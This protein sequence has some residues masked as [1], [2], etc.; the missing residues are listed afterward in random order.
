MRQ[1]KFI[2]KTF[3]LTLL[4]YANS[5]IGSGQELKLQIAGNKETGYSVDIYDGDQLLMNND[6]EFSLL[7]SNLDLSVNT[8]IDSWKADNYQ[9]SENSITLKKS[10]YLSKFDANLSVRVN[11]ELINKNVI[12]KT[13]RLYQPSIP[14]FYYTL[15]ETNVPAREPKSY[16]TFEHEKFPGGFVHELYPSA[17]FITDDNNVVGFLTDAGFKNHFTRTTR[18]RFSENGGGM[19]GM[20]ILPDIELFTVATQQEQVQ[21]KHYVRQTFGRMYDLDGG[22]VVDLELSEEFEKVGNV[23]IQQ[24][25]EG[26]NLAIGSGSKSGINMIT[27]MSGQKI[28]S[29]SFKVKGDAPVAFKL[30]QVSNGQQSDELEHGIKYIDNFTTTSEEWSEFKGSVMVPYIGNDSVMMFLGTTS[31][32]K[33]TIIYVKDLKISENIPAVKPYNTLPLGEEIEKV[34]YIFTEPYL[35]HRDFMI[36]SQTRLAEGTGFEGSEPEKMFYANM[37]MLT[38]ITSVYN[39]APFNVPNMN[40]SP[41][42][43]NRDSFWS[44][45]S[46]HNKELNLSIWDQWAKTQNSRGAIGT[47]ITP[48]MGSVEAKDNEATLEWLMWGLLNNRRFGVELPVNKI[49]KAVKYVLHEFDEDG[50]AICSSHFSM[51]QVDVME[52]NP[53]TQRMAANQG[54]F[55]VALRTIKELGYSIDEDYL[56]K[57]E[58]EYRNFYDQERKHLLFDRDYPDLITTTDLVPEFLSLWLHGHAMLTDEMVIN[59]LEQIPILNKNNNAPYPELGTTAP[60]IIRLTDDSKGYSYMTPDY[61]PFGEFGIYNYQ[62]RSRD[63]FYYNGGSWLRSEYTAYVVGLKHG[64]EKAAKLMENRLWAEFNLNPKM[65]YSKEFIPTRPAFTDSWWNST[66]GLCWNVFVLM[67]NEFAGLRTPEMDPDYQK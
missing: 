28:Y 4:F 11:Y 21:Q 45:I 63:G 34:T 6:G 64:W 7:L 24:T 3:I 26:L 65:P 18:R 66:R 44:V 59:H 17:G 43:Y 56:A 37:Q 14:E 27:P 38:W 35:S 60:T 29:I 25:H 9:I 46:T 36:S 40:Y 53:K 23:D 55:A 54:M 48:Y 5:L 42:M 58:Q 47:I 8:Q 31:G 13:V 16:V 67:A 57:A 61:Q 20:R 33:A 49:D 41:D 32:E 50:D 15:T 1:L 10:T 12:K 39:T 2:T 19:V 52:Y 22:S 62:D 51:T 30:Y